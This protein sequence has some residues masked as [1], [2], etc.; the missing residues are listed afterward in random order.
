MLERQNPD[1]VPPSCNICVVQSL[2]QLC[3]ILD[4]FEPG[5]RTGRGYMGRCV[6]QAGIAQLMKPADALRQRVGVSTLSTIFT[7]N[8]LP[9]LMFRPWSA[10]HNLCNMH[11]TIFTFVKPS[12]CQNTG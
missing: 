10:I 6:Y 5:M 4:F 3:L 7:A 1:L 8:S 9:V 12:C 11:N 2:Q